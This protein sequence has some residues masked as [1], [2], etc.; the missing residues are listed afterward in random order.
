MFGGLCRLGMRREAGIKNNHRH[1]TNLL[2]NEGWKEWTTR[3]DA[4]QSEE[5]LRR[6]EALWSRDHGGEVG[7]IHHLSGTKVV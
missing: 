3:V 6:A 4:G 5:C 2:S 7:R 1:Q